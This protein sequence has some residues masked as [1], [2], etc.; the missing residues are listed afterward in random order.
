MAR[1]A[2]V[3]ACI[4]AVVVFAHRRAEAATCDRARAALFSDGL[5]HAAPAGTVRDVVDACADPEEIA[6]AAAGVSASGHPDVAAAMARSAIAA[7]PREF[8]AWAALAQALGRDDP[9]GAARA[10]RRAEALNPRWRPPKTTAAPQ[11]AAGSAGP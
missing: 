7:G 6:V 10:A 8:A 1:G 9:A 4:V 2:V 5:R 3:V 11:G